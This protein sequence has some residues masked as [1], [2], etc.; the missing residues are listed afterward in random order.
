MRILHSKLFY[1]ILLLTVGI[2]GVLLYINKNTNNIS[3]DF[4]VSGNSQNIGCMSVYVKDKEDG[5]EYSFDN[6][7]TWQKSK[8]G[9]F[10]QNGEKKVLV[11]NQ[12]KEIISEKTINIENIIDGAPVIKVNFDKDIDNKSNK[13]LLKDVTANIRGKD[14]KSTIKIHVLEETID[15]LLVSYLAENNG[16]KCYILRKVTNKNIPVPT[17]N[18]WVWPTK[19]P[20]QITRGVSKSHN[21]VD[22]YGPG[23][24]TPVYA[25]VEGEIVDIS[26]NSS[27]GYYV[28][29]KHNNNFYTRYAHMQNTNGNDKL[30]GTHS[31]KKYISLGQM[32]NA[33]DQ[34]GEVGAS[35]NSTA[36]HL[37]FEVWEGGA[38]FKGKVLNPLDF[39]K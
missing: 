11:R 16:R 31:A 4:F 15:G 2:I 39:Y 1:L 25:A 5:N 13:E 20:Y 18:K 29:I 30:G 21:G 36:I 24:G 19:K 27:S 33:G 8:Y 35:G 17:T 28:T 34:I 23:R 10:Y 6:G 32:V 37:H 12:N 3:I 26:S 38:P 14:V 9:A 7:A 22:I